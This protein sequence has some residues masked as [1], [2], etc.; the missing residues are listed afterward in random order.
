M[1]RRSVCIHPIIILFFFIIW[2]YPYEG[3]GQGAPGKNPAA[4]EM[5][6]RNI[7]TQIIPAGISRSWYKEAVA[8][9][10]EREYFIRTTDRSGCFDAVDHVQHLGYLFPEKGYTA[11]NFNDD[12]SA[13]GIWRTH[14][15]IE[16]IGRKDRLHTSSLLHVT[17][18]GDRTLQYEHRD[19]VVTYDNR[20]QGME[21]SFIIRKRP[22]GQNALQII[23][24][25]EGDLQAKMGKGDQLL[26]YRAGNPQD[27]KL[28]YDNFKVWDAGSKPL[29]AHMCLTTAHRLVLSVDDRHAVYPLTID[30]LN[31][32]PNLTINLQGVLNTSVD[33]TASA[34]G[35]YWIRLTD[36]Q[37]H[38]CYRDRK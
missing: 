5:A 8:K 28:A 35:S 3:L 6:N 31:H 2:T 26:L 1:N 38:S 9:I 4:L 22:D 30:P 32:T 24:G 14:F 34:P 29:A 11:S 7:Y 12:G 15:I 27:V 17:R 13:K 33:E 10:E 16:G 25:L 36:R 18:V 20:R 23:L 37:K 19:Y 21:Q